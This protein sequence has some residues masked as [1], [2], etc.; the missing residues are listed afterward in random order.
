MCDPYAEGWAYHRNI[1]SRQNSM[2]GH[3][4]M[5]LTTKYTMDRDGNPEKTREMNYTNEFGVRVVRLDD[6]WKLPQY[7]QTKIRSIRGIYEELYQFRPDAIMVHNIAFA[8]LGE[9]IR[10][11]KDFPETELYGDTHADKWNSATNFVSKYLLN[12]IFYRYIIKK[13]IKNFD[14]F[15]YISAETKEFLETE[16]RLDTSDFE[17]DPLCC[18]VISEERKGL[19]K[20]SIRKELKLADHAILFVHSGKLSRGKKTKELLEA[21]YRVKSPEIVLVIIG[22]IPEKEKKELDFL[23]KR[24]ERVVFLGWK[25]EDELKKYLAAA[26]LYLQPGTQSITMMN[27]LACGTPVMVYPHRS[28]GIYCNGCE[29]LVESEKDIQTVIEKVKENPGLLKEKSAAAFSVARKWIDS[30]ELS[31]YVFGGRYDEK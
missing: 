11:K 22:S 5:I 14:R 9:V 31:R 6:R 24:D 10:Y 19:Y 16:F 21:F 18:E 27:S 8:S 3:E 1:M 13:Y 2:D 29:F 28:Y 15:F 7:I 12:R 20:N 4:V 23:I 30:R 26:D 25:K 17:L